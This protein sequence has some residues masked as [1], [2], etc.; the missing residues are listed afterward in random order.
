MPNRSFQADQ[1][2]KFKVVRE[3]MFGKRKTQKVL[4]RRRI[5]H[6]EKVKASGGDLGGLWLETWFGW[7][8]TVADI[9]ACAEI[10]CSPIM[11]HHI[12]QTAAYDYRWRYRRDYPGVGYTQIL[13]YGKGYV[14]IGFQVS[15]TNPNLYLL[16]T[17]GLLNPFVVGWDLIK[18]SWLVGWVG[19]FQQVMQS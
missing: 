3:R 5:S 10:I 16:N 15:V 6:W 18:F 2:R 7:L 11:D 4:S 14:K 9:Q 1:E 8:P 12:L 13:A 19:N 17:L